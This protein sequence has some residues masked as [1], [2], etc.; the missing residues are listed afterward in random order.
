[1]D[2]KNLLPIENETPTQEA[3]YVKVERVESSNNN[4]KIYFSVH[5]TQT[6]ILNFSSSNEVKLTASGKTI[7]PERIV[8]RQNKPFVQKILSKTENFGIL[9]FPQINS[10]TAELLFEDLYFE[11]QPD[12]IFKELLSLDIDELTKNQEVRK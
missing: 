2:S 10:Q 6:D 9:I 12:K 11:N 7:G 4:F 1:M 8:D 3:K 5:N